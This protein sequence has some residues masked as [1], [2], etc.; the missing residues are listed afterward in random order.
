MSRAFV[1]AVVMFWVAPVARAERR[2]FTFRAA[3]VA[4]GDFNVAFPRERV[5][6]PGLDGYV[7]GM[8]ARLGDT[9]GRPGAIRDVML[10]HVVFFRR[11]GDPSA[12]ACSGKGQ[13]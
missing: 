2:T 4:M 10:H 13:E 6:A 12:S 1:L 3:P 11:R 8:R 9:R 7:V 5:K